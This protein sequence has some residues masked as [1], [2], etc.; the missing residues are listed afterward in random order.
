MSE[1]SS[2][3]TPDMDISWLNALGSEFEKSYMN[4][5]RDF[6]KKEKSEKKISR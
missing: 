6:L 5:L 3:K 2:K 4:N 1:V